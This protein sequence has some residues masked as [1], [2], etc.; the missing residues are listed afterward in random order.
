[1][2]AEASDPSS[3]GLDERLPRRGLFMPQLVLYGTSAFDCPQEVIQVSLRARKLLAISVHEDE[4]RR[5]MART[6]V[7]L[8]HLVD[9]EP[10]AW[11]QRPDRRGQPGIELGHGHCRVESVRQRLGRPGPKNVYRA[12]RSARS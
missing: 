2:P 9:E 10:T 11:G 7:R 1:M 5:A 3:V 12:S 4:C 6:P 8:R